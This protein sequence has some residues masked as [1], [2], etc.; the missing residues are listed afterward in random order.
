MLE[1]GQV[2]TVSDALGWIG[3][4]ARISIED[5]RRWVAA[6]G[7]D[8][9]Q[10]LSVGLL[11]ESSPMVNLPRPTAKRAVCTCAHCGEKHVYWQVTKPR[12]YCPGGACRQ[13]AFRRRRRVARYAMA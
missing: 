6:V 11:L 13:A 8:E 12:K 3:Y 10:L 9:S 5:A 2:M 4:A 1:G 7:F